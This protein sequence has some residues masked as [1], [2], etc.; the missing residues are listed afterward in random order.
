MKQYL[1]TKAE[2]R[3]ILESALTEFENNP[4]Y[5]RAINY[6]FERLDNILA[7]NEAG[8]TRSSINEHNIRPTKENTPTTDA[9]IR[10]ILTNENYFANEQKI[11]ED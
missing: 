10:E 2:L 11:G 1:L 4:D 6:G 3:I 5:L 9:D 7:T 8:S